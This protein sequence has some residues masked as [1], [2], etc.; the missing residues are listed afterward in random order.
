MKCHECRDLLSPYLDNMTSDEENKR[1]TV[2]LA[3]CSGCYRD[4]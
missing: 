2:H 1:I 4:M 3:A